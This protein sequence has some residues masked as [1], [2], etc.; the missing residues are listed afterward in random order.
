MKTPTSLIAALVALFGLPWFAHAGFSEPPIVYFG[1]VTNQ[2]GRQTHPVLGGTIQW[3]ITP[4]GNRPPIVV[5]GKLEALPGGFSYRIEVPVHKIAGGFDTS[6]G[7]ITAGPINTKFSVRIIVNGEPARIVR[8]EGGLDFSEKQR[9]KNARVDLT[10]ARDFEDS[11]GDGLPDWWEDQ[12][13]SL[14]FDKFNPNDAAGDLNG[15]GVSNLQ[16]YLNATDPGRE[17]LTYPEW[18]ASHQLTGPDAGEGGDIDFDGVRNIVEFSLDT[19]P[20]LPDRALVEQRARASAVNLNRKLHLQMHGT[21]PA[22]RRVGIEYIVESS[23]DLR[24]WRQLFRAADLGPDLLVRDAAFS[25]LVPRMRFIRLRIASATHSELVAD[26]GIWGVQGKSI[27]R[28]TRRGPGQAVIAVPLENPIVAQGEVSGFEG[29]TVTDESAAWSPAQW[30]TAPH[31]LTIVTGTAQGRSFLIT[32]H[33]AQ[34]LTVDTAGADLSSLLVNQDR[35]EIR[36]AHTLAGLFGTPPTALHAGAEADA[37]VVQLWNGTAFDSFFHD[38]TAWQ[39]TGFAGARDDTVIFPE[40]GLLLV[41]R[42]RRSDIVW[43]FGVVADGPR[44]VALPAGET[45]VSSGSPL[46]RRLADTGLGTLPGWTGADVLK[47]WTGR[48]FKG[49][50]YDGA[51]WR[52]EGSR[53]SQDKISIKGGSAFFIQRGVQA[54]EL[55]WLQDTP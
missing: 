5:N 45:L 16:E 30:T 10:I 29:D 9:G 34:S 32:A 31:L 38:G 8:G 44:S 41:N 2:V 39:Q 25:S 6:T 28:Q 55:I 42:G 33:T 13:A 48:V 21:L 26:A 3:T 17:F 18:A 12:F 54:S 23:S 15:D 47:L 11:D 22:V 49:Y 4:S 37:D 14:G 51:H 50:F 19:D 1:Q 24:R 46:A 7:A 43:F 27:S 36:P 52:T 35:F 53:G 40:D 20:N